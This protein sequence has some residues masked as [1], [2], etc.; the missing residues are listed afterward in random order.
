MSANITSSVQGTI[1]VGDAFLVLADQI[2]ELPHFFRI[3]AVLLLNNFCISHV[4]WTVEHP[5][6][7]VQ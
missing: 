2:D 3:D 4:S 6:V 7:D 5:I 1:H